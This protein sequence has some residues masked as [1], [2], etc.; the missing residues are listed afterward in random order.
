MQL[1]A[2]CPLAAEPEA[3]FPIITGSTDQ[4]FPTLVFNGLQSEFLLV[5][6]DRVSA[7]YSR[8]MARRL[9]TN[10]V[11]IGEFGCGCGYAK[12]APQTTCGR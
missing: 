11:P 3:G 5:Y 9:D 12:T 2:L 8:I 4:S 1:F 10:G 7:S 6:E